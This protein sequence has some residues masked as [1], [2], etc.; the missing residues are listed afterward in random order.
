[1][2]SLHIAFALFCAGVLIGLVFGPDSERED[3][4]KID[5][6]LAGYKFAKKGRTNRERENQSE[7]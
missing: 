1:M 3:R 4:A 6:W 2:V 7:N 5:G